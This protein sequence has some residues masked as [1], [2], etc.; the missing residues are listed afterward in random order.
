[1][2]KYVAPYSSFHVPREPGDLDIRVPSDVIG[3]RFLEKREEE[4]GRAL[5]L[6]K[7]FLPELP[8]YQPDKLTNRYELERFLDKMVEVRVEAQL[9]SHR[10]PGAIVSAVLGSYS[11]E[12]SDANW[13]TA[14]LKAP[15]RAVK[16]SMDVIAQSEEGRVKLIQEYNIRKIG[17][18]QLQLKIMMAERRDWL[19]WRDAEAERAYV[20]PNRIE[21]FFSGS[22]LTGIHQEVGFEINDMDKLMRTINSR[23]EGASKRRFYDVAAPVVNRLTSSLGNGVSSLLERPKP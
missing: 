20:A 13:V 21:W 19:N 15:V 9:L 18:L 22:A 5:E 8:G 6:R 2:S 1:M 10:V 3:K 14:L 11:K 4:G 23:I 16:R 7:K 17:F 12:A